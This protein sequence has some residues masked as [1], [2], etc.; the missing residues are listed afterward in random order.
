MDVFIIAG[1]LNGVEIEIPATGKIVHTF[2]LC[3][4]VPGEY[5]LLGAAVIH[6]KNEIISS[7]RKQ[8]SDVVQN[9]SCSGPPFRLFVSGCFNAAKPSY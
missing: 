3:F 1:A 7:P 9:L 2:S 6:Q 5:T 4:L 8:P